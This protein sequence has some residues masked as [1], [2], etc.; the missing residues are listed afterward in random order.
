MIVICQKCGK[1]KGKSPKLLCRICAA[2][3]RS[4]TLDLTN[5]TCRMC[6]QTKPRT[7]FYK[8]KRGCS[9]WCKDCTRTHQVRWEQ[10]KSPEE[11][12]TFYREKNLRIKYNLTPEEYDK[13]LVFQGGVCAICKR[14]PAEFQKTLAVDHD[15]GTRVIRGILCWPC[16]SLLPSRK[17]LIPRLKSALIYLDSPPAVTAL[18][19]PRYANSIKRKRKSKQ[20]KATG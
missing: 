6:G 15:H 16:N 9:R 4:A 19:G 12:K 20:L 10:K 7:A 1:I 13:I 14:S 5:K 2:R 18:G 17:E 8:A 11:R 3:Q